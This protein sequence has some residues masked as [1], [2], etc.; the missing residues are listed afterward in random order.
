M[1]CIYFQA[2]V[3][4]IVGLLIYSGKKDD[5]ALVDVLFFPFMSRNVT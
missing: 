5:G 3:K 4:F 2:A 1:G